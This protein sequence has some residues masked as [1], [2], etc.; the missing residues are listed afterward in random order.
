MWQYPAV[1]SNVVK[2]LDPFSLENL[3]LTFGMGQVN[4]LVIFF[5]ALLSIT[6]HFPQSPLGTTMISADQLDLL[7]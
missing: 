2:Y 5:R 3:S 4:F 7:L 6:N 1:K